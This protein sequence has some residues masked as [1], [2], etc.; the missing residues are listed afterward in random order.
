M[1]PDPYDLTWIEQ[2]IAVGN[3]LGGVDLRLPEDEDATVAALE[4]E[5][6]EPPL[7]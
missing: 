7:G 5:E 2:L 6:P 4:T 3:E 1:A